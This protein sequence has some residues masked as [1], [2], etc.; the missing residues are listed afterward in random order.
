MKYIDKRE[1]EDYNKNKR[2]VIY[3]H[4]LDC[5]ERILKKQSIDLIIRDHKRLIL[6][7]DI[8][9]KHKN[10]FKTLLQLTVYKNS[11]DKTHAL[12]CF[13]NYLNNLKLLH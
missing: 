4:L 13:L 11:K 5:Y 7:L 2:L 3:N 10:K 6:N 9:G 1:S 8:K 12:S